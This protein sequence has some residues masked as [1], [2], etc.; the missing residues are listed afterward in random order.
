M[1]LSAAL[2]KLYTAFRIPKKDRYVRRGEIED[3]A[4]RL[5]NESEIPLLVAAGAAVMMKLL[6]KVVDVLEDLEPN[7]DYLDLLIEAIQE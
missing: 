4:K 5:I 1:A 2:K 7:T 6:E 3:E